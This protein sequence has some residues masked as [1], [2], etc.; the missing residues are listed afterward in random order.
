MKIINTLLRIRLVSIFYILKRYG[1]QVVYHINYQKMH[2]KFKKVKNKN[3][4]KNYQQSN[5]HSVHRLSVTYSL[6]FL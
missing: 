3:K 1:F 5:V 4:N 6:T 2:L